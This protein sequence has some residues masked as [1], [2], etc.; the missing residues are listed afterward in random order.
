[1]LNIRD[2]CLI[3][4]IVKHCVRIEEKTS[5][6]TK[7]EYFCNDDLKEI[8]CFNLLQIGEL[9]K[10]L[11]DE[12]ISQFTGIPWKSIKGLRDRIAHGYGSIDFEM[13]WDT[14]ISSVSELHSYCKKILEQA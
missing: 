4:E 2:K 14:S 12:F 13:I 6:I 7:E 5:G 1:M 10:N 3:V 11:T 8:L 9:A